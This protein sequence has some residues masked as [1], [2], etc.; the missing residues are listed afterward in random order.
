M[1]VLF[2]NRVYPPADGATG[3]LLKELAER[4][5]LRG[6]EITV[7]TSATTAEAVVDFPS[8]SRSTVRIERVKSL[9]FSRSSVVQRALSYLSLYPAL[10]WRALR[11][12]KQDVIITM[13]DPPL[14]LLVGWF[15]KLLR[16]GRLIH[17]AQD[18]YPELAEELGV[19][20]KNGL[21]AKIC[22][23]VSSFA[24]RRQQ[25]VISL[26]RCMNERLLNRG[27]G[28]HNIHII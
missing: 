5:A 2:L 6:L 15:I 12:P 7:V 24:L 4:L 11:L 28:E 19:L 22:R 21:I 20:S 26:V 18:L 14:L 3:H 9:P 8:A 1:K 27:V 23:T 16:G 10:L 17:W 25:K 13:T